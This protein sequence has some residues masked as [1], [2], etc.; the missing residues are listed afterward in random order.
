MDPRSVSRVAVADTELRRIVRA[1]GLNYAKIERAL[2]HRWEVARELRTAR[3]EGQV[4]DLDLLAAMAAQL[5]VSLTELVAA[6]VVDAG[7]ALAPAGVEAQ[8]IADLVIRVPETHR[9]RVVQVMR[10][11]TDLFDPPAP[12]TPMA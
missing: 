6:A 7:F 8:V 1:R 9:M 12:R 4:P 11:V 2:E 3:A 10:S 5:N